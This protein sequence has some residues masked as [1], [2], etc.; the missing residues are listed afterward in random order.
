MDVHASRRSGQS[1]KISEAF[2]VDFWRQEG[3]DELERHTTGLP[4]E[5]PPR[6]VDAATFPPRRQRPRRSL[7]AVNREVAR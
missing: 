1:C 3:R 2:Q 5:L 4:T 6:V 7:P